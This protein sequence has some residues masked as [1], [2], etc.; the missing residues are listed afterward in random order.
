M[1]FHHQH[2]LLRLLHRLSNP[3]WTSVKDEDLRTEKTP[4]ASR[5]LGRSDPNGERRKHAH[6]DPSTRE[7]KE[8]QWEG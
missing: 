6:L 1:F 5:R 3:L 4:V 2:A 8:Y 7:N